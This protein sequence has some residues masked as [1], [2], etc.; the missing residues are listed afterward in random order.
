MPD[1]FIMIMDPF[2]VIRVT[3]NDIPVLPH[4]QVLALAKQIEKGDLDAKEKLITHNLRLI[5]GMVFKFRPSPATHSH[6]LEMA[7]LFHEG[8]KGLIR[9]VEK[10]DWRK[11]YRFST[12]GNLW[13]RQALQ[14]GIEDSG[15]TIRAPADIQRHRRRVFRAEVSLVAEGNLQP[16]EEQIA[17]RARL[18]LDRLKEVRRYDA[19][20][21]PASIDTPLEETEDP[22][23]VKV[24]ADAQAL[25]PQAS[26]LKAHARRK[27][28]DLLEENLGERQA[29][30]I[31]LRIGLDGSGMKTKDVAKSLGMKE[32]EVAALEEEALA[33]LR[34]RFSLAELEEELL[35][36]S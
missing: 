5:T 33:K 10:F 34:S 30:V 7:D 26:L 25:D 27:L 31:G 1:D 6:K 11:G 17:D 29:E 22:T 2:D 3:I 18:S 28:V 15:F 4:W 8:V 21:I 19:I 36:A 20:L 12:Y 23:L 14:R 9:A 35:L 24:I 13:I 16:T 32:H